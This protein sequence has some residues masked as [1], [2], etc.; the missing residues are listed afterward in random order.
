MQKFSRLNGSH[1]VRAIKKL[2]STAGA[3]ITLG[4]EAKQWAASVAIC[5]LLSP[6]FMLPTGVYATTVSTETSSPTFEPVNEEL[7]IWTNTW[8]TLNASIESNLTAWRPVNVANRLSGDDTKPASDK[9]TDRKATGADTKASVADDVKAKESAAGEAGGSAGKKEVTRLSNPTAPATN[10]GSVSMI[11]QLPSSEHDSIYSYQN[12]L[13]SP[14]GQVEMDSPNRSAALPIKHRVGIANFS[15]GLPL[16]SIPGRGIDASVGM[17]YNSRTWNKSCEAYDSGGINCA[18][19]HF[20]YDVE[21]SWIAPG[22]SSGFGYL[23]TSPSAR[24]SHP[25]GSSNVTNYTEIVPVGITD[26]DG[27]RH[28]LQVDSSSCYLAYGIDGYVCTTYVSIDGTNIKVFGRGWT[29]N[30]NNSQ[31]VNTTDYSSA[32]FTASYNNGSKIQFSGGFLS[33]NQ[34]RHYPL[35]MQDNNGNRLRIAYK[36][37]QSGSIDYITDTLNRR[38]KFYYEAVSGAA[39]K[40]VA[41]TIPGTTGE[42]QTVRF[43][44][45]DLTL[46][47]GG[48]VS[49]STVTA[50]ATVRTL[51]YVYMPATK[52]GYKYEYNSYFGMINK[53]TRFVGITAD[54]TLT[55]ATGS[56]TNEGL[57]AAST[58]YNYPTTT[59]VTDEP[60]YTTRTD[61]WQG[62]TGGAAVTAYDAPVPA[63]GG[64]YVSTITVPDNGFKVETKTVSGT[65]GMLRE[66]TITKRYGPAWQYSQLMSKTEYHWF[67][68]GNRNLQALEIT[69]D[70]GLKKATVFDY[71]DYNNQKSSLE[72]GY[73]VAYGSCTSSN[74][75]RQTTTTFETGPGWINANLLGLPKVITTIVGG[76]NVSK[77]VLTY[78]H[79]T[80][81]VASDTSVTRRVDIDISTHDT[82]Y[83]PDK[84]AY[85]ETICP[86]G[87]APAEGEVPPGGCVVIHHAGYTGGSA[88]RGNLTKV[89]RFSD[90]T[91]VSDPNADVSEYNHDIAGNLVSATLSCCNLKTIEYGATF[92]DTGYAYPTSE[93]KGSSPTQLTTYAAYDRNTGLTLSSTNENL[94]LTSYEYENDTLRPKKTIYPNGGYSETYYSDKEQT[95]SNLLPG[96]VRQKTTLETNK[97]AQS[98][99]YFD[100]SGLGI[101]TATQTPDGWS[102]AALEN[103]SLGRTRKSYNPFYGSTPTASIPT[104][105]KFTELTTIDALGRMAEVRMQDLTTVSTEYSSVTTTPAGFNK[106]FVT[107]MDQAGKKR[108]QLADALGRIVRVDEPDANGNLGAVDASLPVQQTSYE[109]DG[110][111]N[112]SR[113]SQSDGTVTQERKFK[114]D[115]MSRLTHEKQVEADS[116]LTDAGLKVT[117][118]GLWTKYLK[119]K[120]DGLLDYGVD[121]RGVKTTFAYD[122]LNRVSTVNFTDGTPAVTY[123]YDQARTGFYNLGALTRVETADGGTARPDT[124]A[125]ATEFDYDLMGR[126]AKHRQSIGTQTYNLEYG[127]NIAGQLTSEK[128]PSGKVVT[129]SYDANGRL[130]GL[131]DETRSYVNSVQ[132][133]QYG[134]VLS[135]MTLGNSTTQTFTLNDRLQ[136]ASQDLKRGSEV[137]QKYDYG[138]GQIDEGGN[139]DMSKNNGQLARVESWIGTAKQWTKKFSNDHLGRLSEEKELRG[140][141]GTQVYKNVYDFDRFG[142][143]YRKAANNG[144][145]LAYTAIEDSHISKSTNRFTSASVYDDAGNVTQDTKFRSLNYSYDANGRMYKTSNAAATTQ[146][147]AVYDA[148]GMRVATQIDGVWTFFIFDAGGK[149]VAEYGGLQSTDEGGVKYLL[150]DWQGSTRALTSNSGYVQ[151]RID[152]SAFGEEI[153]VTIGQRTAT[154]GFSATNS[155]RQKYGLTERDD[156][157]GLDHTWF[158]KHENRAGRWTGPDPYG[159]SMSKD[160][161]QSFNRYSYVQGQPANFVDPSGLNAASGGFSW[162]CWVTWRSDADGSHFQITSVS[163]QTWSNS[164]GG[165][166]SDKDKVR[167]QLDFY[168]KNKSRA[169][170]KALK[171]L[172]LTDKAILNGFDKNTFKPGIPPTG[173]DAETSTP[174]TKKAGKQKIWGNSTTTSLHGVIDFLGTTSGFLIHE[175]AHAVTHLGDS[176]MYQ[177][178]LKAQNNGSISGLPALGNGVKATNAISTLLNKACR[179]TD[180]VDSPVGNGSTGSTSG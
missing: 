164:G 155:V 137:L 44:Y 42:I 5:A 176:A 59:G 112:L 35:I 118:G 89:T 37:D 31:S 115:S 99:S 179:Y 80:T 111:D 173:S 83:N 68:G 53:I 147:N 75:F 131:A 167:N 72:C 82:F 8:R 47:S 7:P 51:K 109:Y 36:A 105:T 168:L 108:R 148:S 1:V 138:Y 43:Y 13:G 56:I 69:N 163:C 152:Y 57:Y 48:F 91:L 149:M 67:A 129:N 76:V 3:V 50:P 58:E 122:G 132:Y 20:T 4:I 70:A 28:R 174:W 178:L 2:A 10:A 175:L 101:R 39:D 146:S 26:S 17:T 93:R 162:S 150:S 18:T 110:N 81:G 12:N 120:P 87:N 63:S 156:A 77:T 142:N 153:G 49:G 177:S 143:M 95:G 134:G 139:L 90:A 102:I 65:D 106:T 92:A 104:G 113:V 157:T 11:N 103:D 144:S 180:G 159:G 136:M 66:S 86:Q 166:G 140:D 52:T 123:T 133:Q 130:S 124:P 60:K 171:A 6:L 25:D 64:D 62:N 33:T 27:T 15:F 98:Y 46:Q 85:D 160:D 100:G 22:F 145:S 84:P 154:Q 32:R 23:E 121:A 9:K 40:L 170:E 73:G 128:Y 169:C 61:N 135:G 29:A 71:D 127:Y 38:I 94:Q 126:A 97:F 151:A 14:R 24:S 172:G 165:G 41:V 158:R 19:N 78:D 74:A 117:S 16:A 107:T 116:T 79:E 21:Q 30:P 88:Y 141:N 119:Y 125:T 45:E 54:S 55:S 114:Y 96:Y 34:R 161:P